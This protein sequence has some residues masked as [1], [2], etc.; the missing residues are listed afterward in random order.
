MKI[1]FVIPCYRSEKTIVGVVS[2]LQKVLSERV[3]VDYEI[4]MVSDHSPDTVYSVIEKLCEMDPNRVKGF[5]LARNFGQH[6]ALM[7]GYAHVNGDLV[8]SL[9]DDG[10]AP[11][12]Y[13]WAMVDGLMDGGYDAVYGAYSEKRHS[14]FRN[15]GSCVNDRMAEWLLGKPK[16]L[17]IS[18]FFVAKRFV[19]DEM[20]NYCGPFPYLYGLLFRVTRNLGN[21]EVKHRDRAGGSSGYTFSK[22]LGLWINGFTAFSV[23]PLRLASFVGTACAAL[24]FFYGVWIVINKLTNPAAPLGYSSLMAA[25]L[26]I[27]GMVMLI[28]GLIGEYVGRIY[29]CINQSPQYVVSKQTSK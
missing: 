14:W 10:Q 2:E 8:F 27:G 24:G 3:G 12:D 5:E 20:L 22:L 21:V 26:F 19:I 15:L 16:S 23:K 11:V 25:I 28:L 9:D 4:V 29:I 7:A 17:K 18:S 6:A 1:S 13:I